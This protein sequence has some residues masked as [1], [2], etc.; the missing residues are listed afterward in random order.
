[1]QFDGSKILLTGA[2]SGI[3]E[4]LAPMLAERGATLGLVARRAD[5]L[6]QTLEKVRV[7]TPESRSW[8]VDLSD[9][10]AAEAIVTEAWDTFGYLD[11]LIN[12][13]A[14]GKRKHLLDQSAA[15]LDQVMNLNF[16]SPIRMA[17]VVL[18]LMVER[19]E[20]LLVN[21]GSPGGRFGIVHESAY[22]AAKFAMSG[23]SE[24]AAMDLAERETGVQLKLVLPGAIK[25]EIWEQQPGDLPG[26]FDGPW[27]T[28]E[29]CAAGIVE[30]LEGPGFEHYVPDM[31]ELVVGKTQDPDGFIDMMAT[32]ARETMKAKG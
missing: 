24:T 20:G 30:A 11:S 28:A 26:L 21:V 23:W 1:M 31:K 29:E 16:F 13:A 14:M 6:E 2:S 12:N 3:G 25:T 17:M 9:I 10:A 7:H 8:S 32:M 15:E 4:A 18:P 19:G 27:T 5:R 22:C